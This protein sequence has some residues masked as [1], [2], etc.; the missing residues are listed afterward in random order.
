MKFNTM[1]K[2]SKYLFPNPIKVDWAG[3]GDTVFSWLLLVGFLTSIIWFFG[4]GVAAGLF[5]LI[6]WGATIFLGLR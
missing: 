2:I 3:A 5:V 1:N 6:V 4:K